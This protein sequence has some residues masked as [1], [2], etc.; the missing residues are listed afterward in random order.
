[1]STAASDVPY[2]CQWESADLAA[3]FI[4][5]S[6]PA[7]ADPLWARSG[8]ST[9]E[10]YA[11]WCRKV[12]GLACLK[13]LLAA[14][15]LPVPPTMTL[16]QGA[17]SCGA[18]VPAGTGVRGLIYRPFA[19]WVGPEYGIEVH[20]AVALPMGEVL[21]HASAGRPVIASVHPSIRWPQRTPPQ[22]GGH[23]VLVTGLR[24]VAGNQDPLIRL[25]NP[26]GLP[27]ASQQDA[28]ISRADF[29]K[30]FASRGM[31]IKA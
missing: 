17:L 1:M 8:A 7:T 11:F 20:V 2:Y 28:L 6:L 14:R 18:F 19:D 25:H 22:R 4:E 24:D 9:P 10:E 27:G 15:G 16:V 12:C 13:M 30:F 31:I 26:S 23:L 5:G 29:E 21:E 3:R